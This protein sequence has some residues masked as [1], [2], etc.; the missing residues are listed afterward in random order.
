MYAERCPCSIR[1]ELPE[2]FQV[3]VNE[4]LILDYVQQILSE[5]R[6]GNVGIVLADVQL[7]VP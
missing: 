5:K 3:C 1:S 7:A 2:R 4:F 6:V